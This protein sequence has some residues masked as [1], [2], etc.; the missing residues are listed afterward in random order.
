MSVMPGTSDT[1]QRD[2]VQPGRP[3]ARSGWTGWI[4]FAAAL[5]FLAGVA[6]LVQGFVALFDD[7]FSVAG[8]AGPAVGLNYTVWGVVHLMVGA[9]ACLIGVGLLSGNMVARGAA[10]IRAVVVHGGELEAAP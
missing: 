5:L 10:V 7:D 9:L 8:S 6:Q 2:L 1:S 3:S 4:V